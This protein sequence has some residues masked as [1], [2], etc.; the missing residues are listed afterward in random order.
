MAVTTEITVRVMKHDGSEYRRWSAK[1]S[2]RNES[3]LVLDAE[4]DSDVSHDLM[5]DIKRGTRTI[6]Y[7][8]FDRW[9][10]IFQFLNDDGST[11]LWYCNINTPFRLGDA[12]LTY[13]DMDI[14]IVVRPDFSY[15]VL[16]EDE[17]AINTERY[18]YSEQEIRH[19]HEAL[20]ELTS[21]IEGR[22]FPFS[23]TPP[24]AVNCL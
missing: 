16:D 12:E 20:H 14:D 17:F 24:L 13:V 5:G 9:Y 11:R 18:G 21:T 15:Q 4:F 1:V 22:Q 23:L 2:Q 8:W 7:Y 10:S 19:V 3:L 6:E